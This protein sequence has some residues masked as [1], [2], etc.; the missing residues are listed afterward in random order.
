MLIGCIDYF[1]YFGYYIGRLE[2]VGDTATPSSSP[3]P[4]ASE[5]GGLRIDAESL[6]SSV[7]VVKR[8]T[9]YNQGVTD[10]EKVNIIIN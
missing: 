9:L 2:L 4:L 1:W 6:G 10:P 5:V 3:Q 8:S 7:P